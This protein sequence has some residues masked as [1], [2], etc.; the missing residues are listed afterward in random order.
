MTRGAGSGRAAG[1]RA[2]QEA[3]AYVVR[4]HL[5]VITELTGARVTELTFSGGAAKGAL[6]PQ[7]IADVLGLPVHVPAVT[8]SS[9]LGAA[10]CAGTG[11][12]IYSSL[13]ELRPQ[14]RRRGATFE[15]HPAAVDS[16]DERYPA[17][18]DIYARMLGISED[19]LLSPMWRAA[20]A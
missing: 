18:R 3:A 19:G 13:D 17:W 9:A 16:Y 4:G 8:E 15:P 7:V 11:A 6:W 5:A 2:V 1:I 10:I 20:G 12:G 14:L